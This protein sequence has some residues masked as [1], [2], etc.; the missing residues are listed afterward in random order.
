MEMELHVLQVTSDGLES[1]SPVVERHSRRLQT[2]A[3]TIC[4]GD[5]RN[6][7]SSSS[8]C[9]KGIAIF[10]R[11]IGLSATPERL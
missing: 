2:D 1:E 10:T 8:I 4:A 3:N 7:D 6:G 11:A 9:L 5:C